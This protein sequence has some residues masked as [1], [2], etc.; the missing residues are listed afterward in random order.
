M[1]TLEDQLKR[2]IKRHGADSPV[3]QILRNQIQAQKS[4]KSFQS[5]YLEKEPEVERDDSSASKPTGKKE[6]RVIWQG[7]Q[8]SAD[9]APQPVSIL[10]GRNLRKRGE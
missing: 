1:S 2:E 9:D 10:Y 8:T 6:G 5:L 7:W 3:A 4:G